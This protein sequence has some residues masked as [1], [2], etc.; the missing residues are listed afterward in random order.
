MINYISNQKCGIEKISS[1]IAEYIL[2]FDSADKSK[3]VFHDKYEYLKPECEK[4]WL[5]KAK[6]WI[7]S[8]CE[9]CK[10]L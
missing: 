2:R 4:S 1:K 7:D 6:E 10:D 5:E 9:W 3:Y 8:A